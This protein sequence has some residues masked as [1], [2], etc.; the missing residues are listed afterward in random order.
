MGARTPEAAWADWTRKDVQKYG[1]RV[2]KLAD[3]TYEAFPRNATVPDGAVEL[4][5]QPKRPVSTDPH[6]GSRVALAKLASDHP[7][8]IAWGCHIAV[9]IA[10]R[11]LTVHSRMVREEMERRGLVSNVSGPEFW[12]GAVFKT[13]KSAGILKETGQRFK[14]S[15]ASRGI[16]ERE[17]KIWALVEFADT[18]KYDTAPGT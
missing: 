6:S 5:P 12:M 18:E 13:L 3:N 8:E 14:Y 15:D 16:H 7:H 11:S 10:K 2:Y 1:V 17:V 4:H 9:Q